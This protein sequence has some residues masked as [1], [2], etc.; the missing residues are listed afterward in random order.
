MTSE[1][2]SEGNSDWIFGGQIQLRTELDGRDFLNE[3][4]PYSLTHMRTR[5]NVEKKVLNS[6]KFFVEFQ[7]S[8]VWGQEKSTIASIFNIDL[9][10]GYAEIDSIFGVPLS[11]K[12]GRY[13][14]SYSS[15][16]FFGSNN[17]HYASRTFDGL[18][19]KYSHGWFWVDIFNFTHTY[20][21]DFTA[22]YNQNTYPYPPN[23]DT[24]FSIYGLWSSIKAADNLSFDIF[25]Y[26]ETDRRKD[27]LDRKSKDLLFESSRNVNMNRLTSG[28]TINYKI[29]NFST[30]IEGAYQGG[31]LTR[32]TKKT[33]ETVVNYSDYDIS[34]FTIAAR[35]QYDFKDYSFSLNWEIVSGT[36]GGDTAKNSKKIGIF[37]NTYSTKHA[38][39]GFMDYFSTIETSTRNLG[40]QDFYLRSSY[41]PKD[42]QWY[43]QLDI[44]YFSSEKKSA[45]DLTDF[46]TEID[47]ILR[48]SI[49]KN[50]VIEGGGGFFLPGKLMKEIWTVNPGNANEKKREDIAFWSYL[51]L[52]VTL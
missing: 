19:L 41:K 31:T 40:L 21:N 2:K 4:Y 38:L 17:W 35:L 37:D 3:T 25:S 22:N 46:G 48:Y 10:Q 30:L 9:H 12:A 39:Y 50:S 29:Q 42:S 44:H 51:M 20:F 1:L 8:R 47:Y 27:E 28:A 16:R 6:I 49:F 7:D 33:G 23:S 43:A 15:N 36:E 5:F 45:S 14:N 52:R 32:G 18:L 26:Y 24:S 11:A 34:A 13:E